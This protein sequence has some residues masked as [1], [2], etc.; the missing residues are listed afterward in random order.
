MAY[1]FPA[2]VAWNPNAKAGVFNTIFYVY[3]TS[4][5]GFTTPLAITDPFGVAIVGN[6]LNSGAEAIIPEFQQATNATVVIRDI[7]GTY[8]WTII[9]IQPPTQDSAVAG[10]VT[11]TGSATQAALNGKYQQSNQLNTSVAG[12]VSASGATQSAM[13]TRYIQG[14]KLGTAGGVAT[15]DGNGIVNSTQLPLG[16]DFGYAYCGFTGNG[17]FFEKLNVLE[18]SDGKSFQGGPANPIYTPVSTGTSF[19]DPSMLKIGSTYFVAYTANN[20]Y[21]KNF[22]VASSTD[23]LHW[24]LVA[25]V[26]TS[27][28]TSLAQCWAP[29]LIQDTNGDVY[30]FFTNVNTSSVLSGWYVK[31]TNTTTLATW[32]APV[33]MTWT[34]TPTAWIDGTFVYLNGTWY[35]F[36]GVNGVI[37]RATCPTLTGTWT[38]DKTGDWASWQANSAANTWFE[39]PE[40]VQVSASLWRIY[41]DPYVGVN[42][43]GPYTHPGY[44]YSESS[45]NLTTWTAPVAVVTDPGFP[46]G[47][48]MRHGAFVK[49]ADQTSRNTIASAVSARAPLRRADY[50]CS[51][52]LTGN[53]TGNIGNLTLDAGGDSYKVSDFVSV[54]AAQQL[55]VGVTGI[56]AID[57]LGLFNTG[58]GG[59]FMAIKS[60]GGSANYASQDLVG[61]AA[62][63][64]V[65]TS[66]LYLAAGSVLQF[67]ITTTNTV[68]LTGRVRITKIA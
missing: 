44:V 53:A 42:P 57:W 4:D 34:S 27:A 2:M 60:P 10:W 47:Q 52:T 45:D 19:R 6:A 61:T 26:D 30:A 54:P 63:W 13:D 64:C 17:V 62:A 24:T 65:S 35:H 25:T 38:T 33:A 29:E 28:A 51:A 31:A 23:L 49:L 46:A 39:A 12:L 7:S 5:T 66:N 16:V 36:Y 11:Q 14:T 9:A 21:N 1:T 56:Y 55:T 43:G 59:G 15:L 58:C 41:M 20:G 37:Q 18:S 40:L 68:T 67:Y 32:G 48:V 3:A 8:A 50:T 22:E